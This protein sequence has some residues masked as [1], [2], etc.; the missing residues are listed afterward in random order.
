MNKS[1]GFIGGGRI[2]RIILQAFKNRNKELDKIMVYD[3][4]RETCKRLN[5]DFPAI[6]I[7][8]LNSTSIRDIV[9]IALHP[10]VYKETLNQMKK[11]VRQGTVIISLA[12]KITI[13]YLTE[14]LG[15]KNIMRFMPSATSLINK[16]FNP[17]CFSHGFKEKQE[18]L[19][20][21][22]L[23]GKT[24]ETE[25]FKL[26]AYAVISGMLPTYFC[27][28][29]YELITIATQ[30]GLSGLESK[31]AVEQT[32][33]AAVEVMFKT[34]LTKDEVLDLIPVKPLEDNQVQ[35]SKMLDSKLIEF[36]NKIK[37]V[38]EPML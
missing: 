27:F 3:V 12:P 32:M 35:I 34:G 7:S 33:H 24:I 21:L 14:A 25:E 29:L 26:E 10:P 4:N 30:I 5:Q 28:Q 15:N 2:T 31:E 22:S 6:R 13:S 19:D 9:F 20:L 36:F 11:I 8:D 37:P 16:G 17:V 23:L 38:Y 18:I 1:I